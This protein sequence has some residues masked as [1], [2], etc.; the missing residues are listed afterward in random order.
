MKAITELQA[1]TTGPELLRLTDMIGTVMHP[2]TEL[3]KSD[4]AWTWGPPQQ[5]AF[6]KVKEMISSTGNTVLVFYDPKKPIVV[7]ADA[8]SYGIGEVLMHDPSDQL[9]P[10]GFCS[11]KLTE[12]EV[13]YAQIKNECLAAV[14]TCER[15]SRYRVGLPRFQLLT[16]HKPLVPLINHTTTKHH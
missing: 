7:C 5:T 9:C 10:V 1:P 11:R 13:R 2:M 16:D 12:T 8:S 6:T 4:A 15:L 3:L 14:W